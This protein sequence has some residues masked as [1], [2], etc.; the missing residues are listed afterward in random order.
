MNAQLGG[1]H[2]LRLCNTVG[3]QESSELCHPTIKLRH[4]STRDAVEAVD[5]QE[6]PDT[7]LRALETN[8]LGRCNGIDLACTAKAPL[9]ISTSQGVPDVSCAKPE[10]H[11]P[12]HSHRLTWNGKS[13]VGTFCLKMFWTTVDS[14]NAILA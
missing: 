9:A 10:Q 3:P 14:R 11:S 4:K 8:S 6:V 5:R 12:T 1:G 13:S 7:V 2:M